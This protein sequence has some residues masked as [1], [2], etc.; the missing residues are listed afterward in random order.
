MLF[1]V[2]HDPDSAC[3]KMAKKDFTR[4]GYSAR[5]SAYRIAKWWNINTLPSPSVVDLSGDP[6]IFPYTGITLATRILAD[7]VNGLAVVDQLLLWDPARAR[8]APCIVLLTLIM[9][10]V[11]PLFLFS[12]VQ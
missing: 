10:R 11:S 3:Q 2:T 6:H 8:I 1:R 7:R 9:I 5:E 4:T 12:C